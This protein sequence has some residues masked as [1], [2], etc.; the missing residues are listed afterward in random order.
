MTDWVLEGRGVAKG[1][2][3]IE[4]WG[5]VGQNRRRAQVWWRSVSLVVG[6]HAG[7]RAGHEMLWRQPSRA[8][9]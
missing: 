5:A 8:S 3:R 6:E 9:Q 7:W 4:A 1:W 2:E